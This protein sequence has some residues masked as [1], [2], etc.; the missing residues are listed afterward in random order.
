MGFLDRKATADSKFIEDMTAKA[1]L[2]PEET[3]KEKLVRS[4]WIAGA[5][6]AGI[7]VGIA[8]AVAASF[9][10]SFGF[11]IGGLACAVGSKVSLLRSSILGQA[12]WNKGTHF[13][14]TGP[15]GLIIKF[16]PHKVKETFAAAA[17]PK[18]PVTVQ[19]PAIKPSSMPRL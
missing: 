16:D 7:A 15:A 8:G 14:F 3:L 6:T 10:L 5:F 9:P 18:E 17:A 1:A 12:L 4:N 13:K 19:D 11:L 2:L